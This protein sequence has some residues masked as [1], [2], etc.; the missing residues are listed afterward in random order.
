MVPSLFILAWNNPENIGL[1]PDGEKK[2]NLQKT[3]FKLLKV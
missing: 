1:K 3:K 2:L